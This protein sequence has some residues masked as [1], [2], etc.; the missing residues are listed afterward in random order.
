MLETIGQNA[1]KVW[2]YLDENGEVTLAAI[3]KDLELKGDAAALSIGWLARE[4]KLEVTKK[5]NSVKVKL[6]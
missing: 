5:G 3:K 4:G 6:I 2:T 1:G